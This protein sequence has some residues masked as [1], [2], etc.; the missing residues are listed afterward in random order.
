MVIREI[1]KAVVVVPIISEREWSQL[2]GAILMGREGSCR[3]DRFVSEA[4]S[5]AF[6]YKSI[7]VHLT[8]LDCNFTAGPRG[9]EVT[10]TSALWI[11]RV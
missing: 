4:F 10:N 11:L 1:V 6:Y 2:E 9:Q 5:L 3:V 7:Q 8:L